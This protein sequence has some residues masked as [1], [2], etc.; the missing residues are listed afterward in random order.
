MIKMGHLSLEISA[1]G[2]ACLYFEEILY[3]LLSESLS[4]PPGSLGYSLLLR[5]EHRVLAVTFCGFHLDLHPCAMIHIL[6]LEK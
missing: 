4:Q 5:L 2:T 6:L 1:L 3:F